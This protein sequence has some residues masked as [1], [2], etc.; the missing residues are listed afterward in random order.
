M[1]CTITLKDIV[2]LLGLPVDGVAVTSST[3]LRWRDVCHSLLGLIPGDTNLDGN[4]FILH[5]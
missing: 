2:I 4:A 3:S 1:E 5:G